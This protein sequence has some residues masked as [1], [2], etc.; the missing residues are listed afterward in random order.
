MLLGIKDIIDILLVA[1]ILFAIYRIL[2][3]SGASNLIWGILAFV[4][5]WLLVSY[6]LHLELTSGI[7]DRFVSV[8]AIGLIVIFQEE[9]RGFF[10]RVGSRFNVEQIKDRWSK[11]G[12]KQNAQQQVDAVLNACIHMSATKTGAL[13]VITKEQELNSFADTGEIINATLSTRLIENI[14]FKNTPLHDGALIIHKGRILS[15][16]CILPV[17]KRTDLPK[18]YGLRHRAAIG[19]TEKTDALAI[20]VSEETGKISVAKGD[21]IKYAT[22]KELEQYLMQAF[23]MEIETTNT[24]NIQ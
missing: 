19:L 23:G 8:G 21:T 4:I 24:N 13:I 3:R 18:R 15:A 2:R 1:F 12:Q 7:F 10:Y 6:L 11:L 20:V 17:S 5:A 14:F 9:I 16:A 22:Q